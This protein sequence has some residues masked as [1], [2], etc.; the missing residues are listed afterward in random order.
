MFSIIN[1]AAVTALRRPT[2]TAAVA[3]A[4]VLMVRIAVRIAAAV[5]PIPT[6]K[7]LAVFAMKKSLR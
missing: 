5:V 7:K 4:A 6:A 3:V 2:I 1:L